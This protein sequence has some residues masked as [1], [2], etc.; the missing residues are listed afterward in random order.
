MKMM[1]GAFFLPCSNN[2]RATRLA[3]TP[4]EHFNEVR[5]RNREE[6]HIRF[7]PAKLP[8][9][10]AKSLPVPGGPNKPAHPLGMRPPNFW[11][12]C[13]SFRNSINFLQTSLPSPSSLP[14]TILEVA[15]FS[16][17]RGKQPCFRDFAETQRLVAARLH[18]PHQEKNT[19]PASNSKGRA[20]RRIQNQSPLR[21]FPSRSV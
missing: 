18:L 11:N 6:R 7:T 21:T 20:F 15:F 2:S 10:P 14:A 9:R 1:Q 19:N 17:L 8:T 5:T 16:C 4:N 13:G 3:P 12:F